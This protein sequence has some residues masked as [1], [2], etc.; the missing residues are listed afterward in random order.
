MVRLLQTSRRPIQNITLISLGDAQAG[1]FTTSRRQHYL[2]FVG[3]LVSNKVLSLYV[4][5]FSKRLTLNLKKIYIYVGYCMQPKVW[6]L[7]NTTAHTVSQKCLIVEGFSTHEPSSTCVSYY[8]S[9]RRCRN[10]C[11]V[12]TYDRC[13]EDESLYLFHSSHNISGADGTERSRDSKSPLI[14]NEHK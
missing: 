11:A 4:A 1:A 5:R 14:W 9:H 10:C 6:G 7:R 2:S 12:S 3:S 8:P 13:G